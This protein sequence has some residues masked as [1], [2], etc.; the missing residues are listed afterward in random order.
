MEVS[1]TD[2]LEKV[3]SNYKLVMYGVK[4]YSDHTQTDHLY[5]LVFTTREKAEEWVNG[6]VQR[7]YLDV[8]TLEVNPSIGDGE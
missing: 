1:L 6:H 4:Y 2:I 7:S 5:P 8:V 3:T